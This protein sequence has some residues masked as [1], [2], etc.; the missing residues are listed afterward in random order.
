MRVKVWKGYSGFWWVEP[1]VG[2]LYDGFHTFED[3]IAAA[4]RL[5]SGDTEG[6]ISDGREGFISDGDE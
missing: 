3:A 5:A 1:L 4:N 2:G 6:F